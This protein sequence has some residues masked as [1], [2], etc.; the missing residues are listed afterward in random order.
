MADRGR[1]RPEVLPATKR[2]AARPERPVSQLRPGAT[3]PHFQVSPHGIDRDAHNLLVRLE[4]YA[5]DVLR[6]STDFAVDWS[7]NQA[8]RDVQLL[9]LQQKISGCWRTLDG[10]TSYCAI[11]SYI[12]TMKKQRHDVLEGLGQFFLR[13]V[14]LPA[15]TG[16]T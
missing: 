12:S 13:E 4:T 7:N 16:R 3:G 14:W 10:A 15:G 2:R 1:L 8:E 6:F 9:K 11:H 5:E